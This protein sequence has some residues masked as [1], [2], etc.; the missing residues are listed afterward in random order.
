MASEM[1]KAVLDTEAQCSAK[2]AEAKKEAELYIQSSKQQAAKLVANAKQDAEQ[3]LADNET[4][5][6]K[7]SEA[8]LKKAREE[9]QTQCAAISV[10]AEKNI[11]RVKKLVVE[12]LTKSPA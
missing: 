1:L 5:M 11:G 12:M 2:E 7:K 4:D 10:N 9:A 6:G 8:E 3:M